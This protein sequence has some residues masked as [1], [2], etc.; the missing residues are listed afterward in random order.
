MN[1]PLTAMRTIMSA[2]TILSLRAVGFRFI[3]SSRMGSRPRVRAGG[4][5]MM[6][7][8]HKRSSAEKGERN[9][10]IN[11]PMTVQRNTVSTDATLTVSWNWMKRL[12]FS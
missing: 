12:K 6:M 5:S 9:P 7:L 11:R 10:S 3:R 8:I 1:T 4:P 2:D